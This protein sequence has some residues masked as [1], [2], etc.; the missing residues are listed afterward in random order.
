M[1]NSKTIQLII[2]TMSKGCSMQQ[3]LLLLPILKPL[4][5]GIFSLD[6]QIS[7]IIKTNLD[8]KIQIYNS[9]TRL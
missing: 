7:K 6:N 4:C 8:Q 1:S 9:N 2:K 5:Q 3:Q